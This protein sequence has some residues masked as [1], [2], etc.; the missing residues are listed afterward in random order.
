[1]KISVTL[2]SSYLYCKRRLF[3]E[4]ILG[5]VEPPKEAMI[6][7]AVRHQALEK[8]N[9][10][11][12]A[13]VTHIDKE[14]S[15]REIEDRFI[16]A[17]AQIVRAVIIR[18][19]KRMAHFKVA[20][21]QL[22]SE[23]WPYFRDDA[24][25]RAGNVGQFMQKHKVYGRELWARLTPKIVSELRVKSDRLELTGI[26]DQVI[27]DGDRL[28]PVEMKTGK[29]PNEGVWPSHRVQIGAYM[30]LL[31]E[32]YNREIKEG[33]VRYLDAGEMRRVT[34]NPFL[35][36]EIM[37]LVVKVK[38]LLRS[39]ALPPPG[40]DCKCQACGLK[41]RCLDEKAIKAAKKKALNINYPPFNVT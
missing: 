6:R 33:F 1:M 18:N 41:S 17:Y 15:G 13:I 35:E 36:H 5:I 40:A 16:S 30:L 11:E 23:V 39:N 3:L 28:T 20:P 21:L 12:E 32:K 9:N 29:M 37:D 19:K 10:A 34:M 7:G 8:V 2:L 27:E 24:S 25:A 38:E 4:K 31:N 26:V 22:F 14:L